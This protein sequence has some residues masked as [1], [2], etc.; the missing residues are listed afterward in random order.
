MFQSATSG[1]SRPILPLFLLTAS[2][3]M[4]VLFPRQSTFPTS[5]K[6]ASLQRA[7]AVALMAVLLS[8]GQ[9]FSLQSQGWARSKNDIPQPTPLDLIEPD[10]LLPEDYKKRPLTPAEK[11][12]LAIA[13]DQLNAEARAQL[14]LGNRLQAFEIWNRELRL[15]R[16][17]GPLLEVKALGRVG[18]IAWREENGDQVRL[19]TRRLK[20]IEAE[21]EEN[22]RLNLPLRQALA[23]AYEQVRQRESALRYYEQLLDLAQQSNDRPK[24]IE[25]LETIGNLHLNWFYFPEAAEVYQTLLA[26]AEENGNRPQQ[27]FYLKRRIYALDRAKLYEPAIAAKQKLEQF[28][29]AGEGLSD[30]PAEILPPDPV[31]GLAEIPALKLSIGSDYAALGQLEAAFNAFQESYNLAWSLQHYSEASDALRQMVTLYMSNDQVY[32]AMQTYQVL[33]LTDHKGCNLYGKMVS[34]DEMSHIYRENQDY[35]N[36]MLALQQGLALAKT[37]KY[38]VPYFEAQMQQVAS[39]LPQAPPPTVVFEENEVDGEESSPLQSPTVPAIDPTLRE[40]IEPD[41]APEIPVNSRGSTDGIPIEVPEPNAGDM[42]ATPTSEDD[43]EFVSETAGSAS[44][45]QP[46]V[47]LEEIYCRVQPPPQS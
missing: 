11:E 34:Y 39:L 23:K 12:A 22:E 4:S 6:R 35:G 31:A 42:P 26:I 47:P 43:V 25:L 38:R 15:R 20:E 14:Q 7:I 21:E 32:E 28:Y 46:T 30:N 8:G 40:S 44:L 2:L 19:V 36:A 16:F 27:V 17:L 3:N 24:E 13:L 10:P 45:P 18:D 9:V 41:L 29:R 1:V 33:L 37:L 5:Q